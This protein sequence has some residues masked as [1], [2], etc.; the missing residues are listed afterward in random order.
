MAEQIDWV[1]LGHLPQLRLTADDREVVAA[2]ELGLLPA[3]ICLTA[4]GEAAAGTATAVVLCDSQSTP[5]ALAEADGPEWQLR[6]LR[7]GD[8]PLALPTSWT[9][10][11]VILDGPVAALPDGLPASVLW[12]VATAGLAGD[13]LLEQV[14]AL[15]RPEDLVLRFPAQ[16]DRGGRGLLANRVP[17]PEQFAGRLGSAAVTHLGVA[18]RED[19]GGSVVFFTGLSGSGK[20]TLAGALMARLS[21]LTERPLTLLDGDEVRQVLSAELGFDA[22]GRAANIRRIAWVAALASRH[23]GI[24]VAAP[25]APFSDGREH[26]RRLAAEVGD[27]LLVWVATGLATCE[28]RDR[29]GLYARARAGQV[30]EFTG[31]SSPYEEPADADLIIDTSTTSVDDGVAEII[32]ELRRRGR[33]EGG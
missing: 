31:I 5:L 3:R 2:I 24:A 18:G 28:E 26:A 11:V 16:G 19:R 6:M 12:I 27:F 25:I 4:G 23:G 17:D 10:H 14:R 30:A 22:E 29:K 1:A 32:A 8:R 9:G 20:S 21:G 13:R 7:P 15:A 33:L